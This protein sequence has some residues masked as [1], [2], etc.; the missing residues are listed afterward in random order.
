MC[1]KNIFVAPLNF[2]ENKEPE[3]DSNMFCV[4]KNNIKL[5]LKSLVLTE[6][7]KKMQKSLDREKKT[8]QNESKDNT[9]NYIINYKFFKKK[10]K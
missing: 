1:K 7:Y 8:N 6:R 10:N 5:D 2:N 4:S 3:E 9:A